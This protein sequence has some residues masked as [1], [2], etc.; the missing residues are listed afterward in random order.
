MRGV[1]PI[2]VIISLGVIPAAGQ[3]SRPAS[4][5]TVPHT[6]DG[7]PDLQGLWN[8]TTLTPLERPRNLAGKEFF[9]EEEAIA[10]EKGIVQGRAN[11]PNDGANDVADPTV[12]WE[13]AAKVVS[14]RRTSLIVDPT[15][16]RIPPLTREAQQRM[17]DTRA[18]T[19]QHPADRAADRS[20]QERCLLSP[21]SGPPMLPGPYNNNYQ[22]VQTPDY[23]MI[24]IEMIH[25]VRVI[26]MDGRPHLPPTIRK[27][28]GDSVGHWENNALVVDTTNFTEKTHFRGSDQ[29]LHLIERF[30]RTGP[31]TILYEFTVDDPTAFASPWKAEIPMILT[32]GPMYEFACHEGNLALERILSIARRAEKASAQPGSK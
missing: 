26:S 7:R 2:I 15:D 32:T 16:G 22:I 12:W 5:W 9:T 27:W 4:A 3:T 19:S 30:T 11:D 6:P 17:A 23:V 13:R 21:T 8:N 10:Y 1:K 31:E 18:A 24:T 25:D 29:N 28:L 14:T 20:L